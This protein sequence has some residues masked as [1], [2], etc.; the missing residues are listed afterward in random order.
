MC[1][2][3]VPGVAL[4]STPGCRRP[5]L[6]HGFRTRAGERAN[7]VR[8]VG[9]LPSCR[10]VG[11]AGRVWASRSRGCAPLHPGLS[12]SVPLA[13]LLSVG[14]S[15]PYGPNGAD[16]DSPGWSAAQPR[17]PVRNDPAPQRGATLVAPTPPFRA[18]NSPAPAHRHNAS[19][20]YS[21]T[22]QTPRPRD[23][24][25][26]RRKTNRRPTP[27]TPRCCCSPGAN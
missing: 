19:A 23:A 9:V 15:H 6:W 16:V 27:N 10:P 18:R 12:T 2:R 3:L 24:P 5:C 7:A 4:R 8:Y 17:V 21:G 13:R 1:G 26:P 20:V 11:A 25:P 22:K 14:V